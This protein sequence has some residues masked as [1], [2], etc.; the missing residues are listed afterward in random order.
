[1]MQN[2]VTC[3]DGRNDGRVGAHAGRATI[4]VA[5]STARG[6]AKRL[7]F[8]PPTNQPPPFQPPQACVWLEE[9][10]KNYNKCLVV[11]SHSQVRCGAVRC[12]TARYEPSTVWGGGR[13]W[14]VRLTFRSAR[15]RPKLEPLL[16]IPAILPATCRAQDFM[17]GVCTNIIWLTHNKLTYY[18]GN[19]DTFVK[20]VQE[21]EVGLVLEGVGV[22][23]GCGGMAVG[24]WGFGA[25]GWWLS[26][27]TPLP[28]QD[29]TGGS[30]SRVWAGGCGA[31]VWGGGQR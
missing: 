24:V 30:R 5:R 10:L 1:M 7:P 9:Y 31:A 22:S 19:Y 26:A 14:G 12:G 28:D 17:N 3:G 21:N 15:G 29:H 16:H 6:E 20:T 8:P 13:R 23:C 27:P 25:G 2:S 4:A 18:T 11:V